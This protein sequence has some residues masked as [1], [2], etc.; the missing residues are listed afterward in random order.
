MRL[1]IGL[2]PCRGVDLFDRVLTIW[3]GNRSLTL[4]FPFGT[5][6]DRGNDITRIIGDLISRIIE[7]DGSL[8]GDLCQFKLHIFCFIIKGT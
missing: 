4:L 3:Q 7:Q 5:S 1:L 8:A 2:E 6:H